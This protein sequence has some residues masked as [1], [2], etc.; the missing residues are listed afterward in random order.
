MVNGVLKRVTSYPRVVED[1]I[2]VR[3]DQADERSKGGILMPETTRVQPGRG[4]ILGVG[5]GKYLANGARTTF[6]VKEG[7]WI[8]FGAHS[9]VEIEHNGETLLV[10]QEADVLAIGGK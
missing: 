9:G 4:V 3:R 1:R 8:Q 5:P 10:M 7:D 2:L 6:D